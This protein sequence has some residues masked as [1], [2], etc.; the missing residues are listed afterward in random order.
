MSETRTDAT[1]SSPASRN[2]TPSPR[3]PLRRRVVRLVFIALVLYAAYLALMYR[4]QD[5]MIFVV[6]RVPEAQATLP[7]PPGFERVMI[8]GPGGLRHESWFFAAPG[9]SAEHP[10]PV[11]IFF[12]GNADMIDWLADRAR[13]YAALGCSALLVEYPGYRA[14]HGKPSEQST[15]EE[16]VR[17]VELMRARPGVDANR[18]VLHG[19]SLGT[20]VAA[21]VAARTWDSAQAGPAALILDSPFTSVASFAARYLVPPSI[22]KHPFHTDR[23]LGS[24][25]CPILIIHGTRDTIIPIE[26]GRTLSTLNPRT[27][28]VELDAG[29]LDLD[30]VHEAYWGPIR[31][32]L[33]KAGVISGAN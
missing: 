2:A 26:H 3:P 15:V 22:V 25:A 23:V 20:G 28:T 24:L 16:G 31:Q 12:H 19:M 8:D 10:A 13:D 18:I 29:H 7:P 27:T 32:F 5:S 11:V 21:Q 1:P 33:A 9:A 17:A 6:Q 30:R 14:N 4:A